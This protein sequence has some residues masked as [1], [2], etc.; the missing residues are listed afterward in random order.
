MR[1]LSHGQRSAQRGRNSSAKTFQT[2]TLPKIRF[3][4]LAVFSFRKGP[5]A[6]TSKGGSCATWFLRLVSVF[7]PKIKDPLCHGLVRPE[8]AMRRP[9]GPR[10]PSLV[11]RERV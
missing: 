4:N 1:L 5:R 8:L 3:S 11:R 6:A 10:G 9:G 2:E 7:A